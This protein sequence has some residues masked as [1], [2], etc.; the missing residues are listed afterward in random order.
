MEFQLNRVINALREQ[1]GFGMS[2]HN[3]TVL[4]VRRTRFRW[5]GSCCHTNPN[6]TAL[7]VKERAR[8]S[9]R[10]TTLATG[11][12]LKGELLPIISS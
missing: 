2:Q 9:K 6:E 7:K 3:G 11:V 4:N 10:R 8:Q 5:T 12:V 1:P